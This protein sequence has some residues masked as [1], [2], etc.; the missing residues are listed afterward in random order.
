MQLWRFLL[1]STLLLTL[2]CD[3]ATKPVTFFDADEIPQRLSDWR[4]PI[5]APKRFGYSARKHTNS[6]A[7]TLI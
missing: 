1:L 7:S 5:T 3:K 4:L 6:T 2:G